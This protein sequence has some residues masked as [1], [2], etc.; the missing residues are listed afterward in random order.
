M[1]GFILPETDKLELVSV[2]IACIHKWQSLSSLWLLLPF[3]M[4]LFLCI[5]KYHDTLSAFGILDSV[6]KKQIITE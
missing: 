5:N 3:Y 4:L 2:G 1:L 6:Q